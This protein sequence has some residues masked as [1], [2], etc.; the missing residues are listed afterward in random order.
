MQNL[1]EKLI[2]LDIDTK[3]K[4][5]D[6]FLTCYEYSFTLPYFKENKVKPKDLIL[7]FA[8]TL[9]HVN[10]LERIWYGLELKYGLFLIEEYP[11]IFM[12]NS[13]NKTLKDI[14][15]LDEDTLAVIT[16]TATSTLLEEGLK[17]LILRPSMLIELEDETMF[18]P[19]KEVIDDVYCFIDRYR[20]YIKTT[21]INKFRVL[22]VKITEDYIDTDMVIAEV[23]SLL[24]QG[25]FVEKLYPAVQEQVDKQRALK[26][27]LKDDLEFDKDD[28]LSVLS[29]LESDEEF[30]NMTQKELLEIDN[31]FNESF[32]DD[33]DDESEDNAE[34]SFYI[35]V[36][37]NQDELVELTATIIET[38]FK[39]TKISEDI[40]VKIF[41]ELITINVTALSKI[42]SNNVNI[43]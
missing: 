26:N 1:K 24:V 7:G 14:N 17:G 36:D 3:E 30:E 5:I 16:E 4:L 15:L 39:N 18:Y 41:E 32:N 9:T 2:E 21:K 42:L 10:E 37:I 23:W 11:L 40:L 13:I 25:Y 34:G 28:L 19:M 31:L 35:D 12:K 20:K 43:L 33:E 29:E 22:P 6:Y 27:K 38:I 8:N